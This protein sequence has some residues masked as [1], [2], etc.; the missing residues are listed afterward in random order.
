M[1]NFF[2]EQWARIKL[3]A[4]DSPAVGI[5]EV[6]VG[7]WAG[8]LVVVAV[9][10]PESEPWPDWYDDIN[11][12]KQLRPAKRRLLRE[13]IVSA[14]RF[15][16]LEVRW[17]G[18]IDMLGLGTCHRDAI[19][20]LFLEAKRKFGVGPLVALVDGKAPVEWGYELVFVPKADTA[21]LNVAA[22]S[23]VAKVDRDRF[24]TEID[25]TYPGYN[26]VKNKG[27]G[28]AEHTVAL[29]KLGVTPM[30]RRSFKPIRD[31]IMAGALHES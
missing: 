3:N 15:I 22:A 12:S 18:E 6:G 31:I 13:K 2:L 28:T 29:R 1:P 19:W 4:K 27:Y 21:S 30:H 16:R 20:E 7:A 26:W 9:S 23:I 10:L 11:D 17:P 24:M 8:P 14:A 5:D 25:L